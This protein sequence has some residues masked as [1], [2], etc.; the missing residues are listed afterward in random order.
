MSLLSSSSFMEDKKALIDL[1]D[2]E[3][4]VPMS[5]IYSF[6]QVGYKSG[7]NGWSEQNEELSFRAKSLEVQLMEAKQ[8]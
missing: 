8:N 2:K 6:A 4:D 1:R 5:P 7:G 3:N